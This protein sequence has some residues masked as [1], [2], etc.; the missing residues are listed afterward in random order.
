MGIVDEIKQNFKQGNNLIKL[1]YI[2]IGVFV[3]VNCIN[4]FYFLF[5]GK[6][7]D[8]IFYYLLAIPSNYSDIIYRPWTILTYMFMHV[9]IWHILF[10]LLWLFWFGQIFLQY[11]DQKKLL[12]VYLLGGFCGAIIYVISYNLLPAFEFF[13]SA[14]IPLLGASAAIMAIVIA[15]STFAP[16]YSLNLLFFGVVKLKYIAI[17]TL[18][19]DAIS[20]PNN[21]AGGYISHLG[22]ALFGYI[23]AIQYKKGKDLTKGL[24]II[25]DGFSSIFKF[26]RKMKVTY[27][28]PFSDFEYNKQKIDNQKEMDRILDKIAKGGYESLTKEEKDFLFRSSK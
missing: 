16:N 10:N 4:L 13:R 25:L 17:V 26:K 22:G 23:F 5:T 12:A 7:L 2:N 27:Q 24:I 21:N 6:K 1:I 20:I 11:L 19:I 18:I 14:S 28:K 9:N 3:I 8:D 15:I